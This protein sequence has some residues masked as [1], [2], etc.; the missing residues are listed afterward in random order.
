VESGKW[1]VGK[2]K[3]ISGMKVPQCQT[4]SN[5]FHPSM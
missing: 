4:A 2:W 5:S 3:R 1:E